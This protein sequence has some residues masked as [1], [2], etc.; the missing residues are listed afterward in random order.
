MCVGDILKNSSPFG[1]VISDM[2]KVQILSA[3]KLNHLEGNGPLCDIDNIRILTPK[4]HIEIH[5][6]KQ[7]INMS[8]K[9]IAD[10]TESEFL[11]FVRCIYNANKEIYPTE[12]AHSNAVREFVRLAEHSDGNGLIYYPSDEREDSPEGVVKE[13]KEWRA[14]H[15]KP[16]FKSA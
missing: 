16:G 14:A 9:T 15:G 4:R 11:E 8:H 1:V 13:L 2:V 10:Y 7:G 12:S 3:T 6:K 5:S